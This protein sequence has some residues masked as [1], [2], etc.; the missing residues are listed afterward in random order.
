VEQAIA[1]GHGH[2]LRALTLCWLGLDLALGVHFP[3][4]TSTVSILG[5]TKGEPSLD[6]WNARP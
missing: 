1:F 2:A 6:Q 5:E 4:D 3:L